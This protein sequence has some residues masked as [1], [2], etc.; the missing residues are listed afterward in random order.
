MRRRLV[1]VVAATTSLVVVAFAVPLGAL[2]RDVARDRAITA[3][4]HDAGAL[5]TVLAVLP[6]AE[7][8]EAAVQQTPTGR[9]GRLAVFTGDRQIGDQT[10]P[11]PQA[12]S[13]ARDRGT[14]F[15]RHTA[16][17]AEIY[18]PVVTGDGRTTVVRARI[19]DALLTD[20]VSTA[21]L[22]LGA[23]A[24]VLIVAACLLADRL[25]RSLTRDA[26]D[27]ASTARALATGDP[28][29]RA[30][31]S[32]VAEI[33]D[34]AGA[35]N[36]LADRIDALRAA[37]RER[38]ADLSH[39]LRTPLT[40]L[41]LEADRTGIPAL[42]EGV[43]RLERDITRLVADA[44][45]PLHDG[46]VEET[47]D[48]AAVVRERCGFW[49]ALAEDDHRAVRHT[50][51][52]GPLVVRMAEDEA[53]ATVDALVNNVFTH[54]ADGTGYG[55]ELAGTDTTVRLE[56]RDDGPGVPDPEAVLGRGVSGGGSSG[57]GL[58]I[59]QHAARRAGGEVRLHSPA[60]GGLAVV[61]EVPR[62]DPAA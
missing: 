14:S 41:R 44:R 21:W 54:T 53:V 6:D 24:L 18:S 28:T 23:V 38:V 42:V 3:A 31:P 8:V 49:S 16:G 1:L 22:A 56:V 26:A 32:P 34:V 39:R 11:D 33:G 51:A 7:L 12:L 5:A 48:L 20:G 37:E 60:G 57:L 27:L 29:A 40:A 52:E 43:D 62:V 45:R 58:D 19:P 13:L 50:I 15:T 17:G 61:V 9:D 55:V 10:P 47:C 59:V 36:A 46:L 25:A 2:V 4:D 30:H 35:L